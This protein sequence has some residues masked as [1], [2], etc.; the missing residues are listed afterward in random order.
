M[1][2][3]SDLIWQPKSRCWIVMKLGQV[4]SFWSRRRVKDLCL[5][6][7][8]NRNSLF[9]HDHT[10]W[11]CFKV[12][13]RRRLCFSC[14]SLGHTQGLGLNENRQAIHY[15]Y[16]S[17]STFDIVKCHTAMLYGSMCCLQGR[18]SWNKDWFK[19]LK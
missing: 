11:Y 13:I 19:L 1:W 17:D 16:S 10:K 2:Y 18:Q 5:V 7:E 4:N 12:E 9:M 14:Y 8:T 6:T 3:Y 15:I